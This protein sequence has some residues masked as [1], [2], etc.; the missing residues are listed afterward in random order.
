[1]FVVVKGIPVNSGI[2]SDIITFILSPSPVP[3]LNII[4][5][6]YLKHDDDVGTHNFCSLLSFFSSILFLRNSKRHRRLRNMCT[7]A[8][9]EKKLCENRTRSSS[10]SEF[11]SIQGFQW[12][13]STC[14][15]CRFVEHIKLDSNRI[16]RLLLSASA[17]LLLPPPPAGTFCLLLPLLLTLLNPFHLNLSF[18]FRTWRESVCCLKCANKF[19]LH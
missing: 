12:N 7:L 2:L 18:T 19:L 9:G 16:Q 1:M 8:G 15:I 13:L 4:A 5:Y 17:H 14:E 6:K 3:P 11:I 10:N